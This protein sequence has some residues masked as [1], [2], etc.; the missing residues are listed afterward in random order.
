MMREKLFPTML[1]F[2]LLFFFFLG[3]FYFI[4]LIIII[5]QIFTLPITTLNKTFIHLKTEFA[6]LI[7][8]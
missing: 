2:S 6:I 3:V 4:F 5:F 1:A 8:T 7:V